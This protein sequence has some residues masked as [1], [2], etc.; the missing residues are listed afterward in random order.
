MFKIHKFCFINI[1]TYRIIPVQICPLYANFGPLKARSCDWVP[2]NLVHLKPPFARMLCSNFSFLRQ[3]VFELKANY[4]IFD[5]KN[6]RFY[7]V[8]SV[9]IYHHVIKVPKIGIHDA[10]IHSYVKSKIQLSRYKCFLVLCKPMLIHQKSRE[11]TKV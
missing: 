4:L 9:L 5:T 3:V 8:A 7:S 2:P 10:F 11:K 6:F 1:G